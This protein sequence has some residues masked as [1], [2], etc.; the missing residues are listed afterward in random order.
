[1]KTDIFIPLAESKEPFQ[2]FRVWVYNKLGKNNDNFQR[3]GKSATSFKLPYLIQF[4]EVKEVPIL[5]A[6][7][8]YN[9]SSSNMAQD[10]EE[11]VCFMIIKE[12]QRLSLG[13]TM[14]YTPF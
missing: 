3:F 9:C 11:L 8:F 13:I 12:F 10:Y 1:M 5:E 4:L 6:L 14:N 7:C 2:E